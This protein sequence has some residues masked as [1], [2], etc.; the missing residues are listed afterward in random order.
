VNVIITKKD[1]SLPD[2]SAKVGPVNN[3]LH[4]LWES[5]RLTINDAPISGQK[6]FNYAKERKKERKKEREID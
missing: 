3:L 5:C 4:S 2:T 1:G 6:I